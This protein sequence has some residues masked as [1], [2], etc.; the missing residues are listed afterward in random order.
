MRFLYKAKNNK[1][2]IVTGTVNAVNQYE[3]EKILVN[4]NLVA[5]E[6]VSEKKNQF[7]FQFL[8]RITLKD[9]ALFARQLATMVSAGLPLTKAM[10]IVISQARTERIK[11]IFHSVLNDLEEGSSFSSALA[12][13]P[14]AFDRVFVSIINS[15]ETTGKLDIVLTQLANQLENDSN[16]LGK[17]KSVM[18]YP[19]FI[20][21][22]LVAVATYMVMVII[23]QLRTIFDQANM[24]LPIATRI[25]LGISDFMRANI[26]ITVLILVIAIVIGKIWL[27]SPSGVR[28]IN[29]LQITI[30]VSKELFEGVYIGRFARVMEMLIGAGVP[31]LDSL[32]TSAAVLKNE[33]YEDGIMSVIS[34]VEKG[35]PLST[36]ML[37]NPIFPQFVGQMVAVGEETG[38]LD[39]VLGKIADYYDE[40]VSSKLKVISS[41]VEPIVLIVIGVGVAFLVFAVLVPIFNLAHAV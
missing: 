30:P 19:I 15:G 39:K 35:V 11:N 21:L 29:F 31:L 7:S 22:A 6:L 4:H 13:H 27:S 38:Q 5:L 34:R 2:E 16:F 40:E 10:T 23:P 12:K 3:A 36:E 14:E 1:G 17:V 28:A 18:Y 33:I 24:D 41:L 37:K 25:L 26:I 8:S 20:V 9:K 32:R